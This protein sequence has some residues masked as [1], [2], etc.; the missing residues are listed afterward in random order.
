MIL[1]NL[2]E[3]KISSKNLQH[4][5]DL[6][7]NCKY[8]EFLLVKPI[9]LQDGSAIK[10]LRKCDCCGKMYERRHSQHIASFKKWNKDL[11]L[12]CVRAGEFESQTQDRRKQ[13]CMKKYG[14]DNPSKVVEFQKNR[15]KTM[16]DKYGVV[17]YFQAE[18]FREKAIQ[19]SKEKYGTD[20][21]SQNS[22]VQKKGQETCL[23]K[24]G[25]SNATLNPDIRQKQIDTCMERYGGVSS[26]SNKEIR[27]KSKETMLKL[28]GCENA[29]QS[30]ELKEKA[31]K[32]R[33]ENGNGISTSKQQL[34]LR[35]IL[36]NKYPEFDCMLNYVVSFLF[37]D[38]VLIKDNLKI[39]VEYDGS[40]WHKDF[41]KD[42]RRDEFLK[43]QGFKILRI[44]SGHLLLTEEQ[45][46]EAIDQLK[47]DRNFVQIILKDWNN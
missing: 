16:I 38:I 5:L 25:V 10:E 43:S 39:D 8:G 13:T 42:R 17:N 15:E 35:E 18:D 7:Y 22:D 32:T 4:Y 3:I 28:Y 29:G 37:L 14:Q 47:K 41:Q 20:F 31:A 21:P 36:E 26:L 11:C 2:I 40:Y 6:G 12:K 19:T 24:Y 44:R 33:L 9:E 45:I 34:Q 1:D 46:E 27:Q 30:A 23:K